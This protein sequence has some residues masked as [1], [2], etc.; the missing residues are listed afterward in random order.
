MIIHGKPST[1]LDQLVAMVDQV[2]WF[3][4]LL[5]THKDWHDKPEL[6]QRSMRLFAEQ[7]MPRLQNHM[8]SRKAAE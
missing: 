5:L 7:V 1:V 2:G 6:H 4:K 8:A 3:G